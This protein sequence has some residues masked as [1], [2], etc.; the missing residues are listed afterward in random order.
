MRWGVTLS[1]A[2]SVKKEGVVQTREDEHF[3]LYLESL[4][5]AVLASAGV[6][7]D[8][9]S[10]G[11]SGD[12]QTASGEEEEERWVDRRGVPLCLSA[13]CSS[14]YLLGGSFSTLRD[15]H[16]GLLSCPVA[17]H[18]LRQFCVPTTVFLPTA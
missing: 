18:L 8:Y 6:D 3:P 4:T 12:E 1:P 16:E 10:R 15:S 17:P 2:A 5:M 14:D 7:S 9:A 11:G 13:S